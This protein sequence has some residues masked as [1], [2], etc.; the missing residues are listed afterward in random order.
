LP[1]LNS[2]DKI[3]PLDVGIFDPMNGAWRKQL[4]KYANMDSTAEFLKKAQ[5]C[6]RK[7]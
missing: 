2:L 7:K 4:K 5:F 3:Q 1:P 6:C